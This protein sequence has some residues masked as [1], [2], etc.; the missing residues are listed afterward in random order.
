MPAL[1]AL[2]SV[3][4]TDPLALDPDEALRRLATIDPQVAA[5]P[6]QD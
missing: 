5:R 3:S 4:L 6:E 2:E 1:W